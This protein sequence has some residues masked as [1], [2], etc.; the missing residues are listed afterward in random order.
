MNNPLDPRASKL[1]HDLV[2]HYIRAGEPI[3]S[4]TLAR[5]CGLDLSPATVRNVLAQLE[6]Q[7]LIAAPHTSAGR[8]PTTQGFRLFVDALIR[9]EPVPELL[10][11]RIGE[12]LSGCSD[13]REALKRAADLLSGL[14]RC[15]SLVRLPKRQEQALAQVDF[16]PLG[17]Q[18]I[19]V[20]LVMRD[21]EV[22]NRIARTDREYSPR[23]LARAAR[24]L[25]RQIA[26]LTLAEARMHF[27]GDLKA[28]RSA[29]DQ[30]MSAAVGAAASLLDEGAGEAMVMA[31][32]RT[33][34]EHSDLDDI[35]HV[36]ALFQAFEEKRSLLHLLERCTSAERV[37]LFIGEESGLNAL[38]PC[39]V[40]TAPYSV[41]G[42]FG[43][44]GVIGPRRLAYQ[45]VIPLVETTARALTEALAR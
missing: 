4:A 7:G 42:Q 25:N 33:V 37:R 3:G 17:Q 10:Q 16:L 6:E 44:L 15:V 45:R 36:R 27:L 31:G 32:E 20:V 1:L 8:V 14:T 18:R 9:L 39:S 2:E 19:L 11:Q 43:V 5:E 13:P 34:L 41:G 28:T 12:A 21:G 30:A 38:G 40:I 23:E 22:Q 35:G 29:I 26:G 24:A